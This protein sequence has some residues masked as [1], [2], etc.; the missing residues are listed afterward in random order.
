M[1]ITD[2]VRASEDEAMVEVCG[3]FT[4]TQVF[5]ILA[6]FFVLGSRLIHMKNVGYFS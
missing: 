3:T 1:R 6:Q 5:F 2:D 4:A